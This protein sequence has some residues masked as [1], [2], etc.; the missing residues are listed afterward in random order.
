M[1]FFKAFVSTLL[2]ASPMVLASPRPEDAGP[3][4]IDTIIAGLVDLIGVDADVSLEAR[5]L[6]ERSGW[7]CSWLG[8]NK[9]CQIKVTHSSC[10]SFLG[11]VD[12]NTLGSAFSRARAVATAIRRSMLRISLFQTT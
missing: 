9:G 3:E 2:I 1:H 4:E 10:T 6:E 11:D 7:T 5:A 8:G 12:T